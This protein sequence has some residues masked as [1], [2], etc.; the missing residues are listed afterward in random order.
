MTVV[1]VILA[2]GIL[3]WSKFYSPMDDAPVS[4]NPLT[5][6]PGAVPPTS[7]T[8]PT[9]TGADTVYVPPAVFPQKTNFDIVILDQLKVFQN[10]QPTRLNPGELGRENPFNNY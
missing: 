7:T 1:A 6:L 5:A 4:T 2:G 3:A 10:F 8:S 9:K